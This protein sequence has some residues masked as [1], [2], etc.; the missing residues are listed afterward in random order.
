MK[1]KTYQHIAAAAMALLLFAGTVQAQTVSAPRT[2]SYQGQL[3]QLG[4][5]QTPCTRTFEISLYADQA[6]DS[7]LWR[8]NLSAEVDSSG[9]FNLELCGD[10]PL[11]NAQTMDRPIWMGI[12]IDN[13]T[14]MR[15]L[16]L[17]SASPYAL[18]V[19]DRAISTNKV[20]DGAITSAK[21]AAGAVQSANLADSSV[22]GAKMATDYVSA[23]TIN[24][25][26]VTS[27]G[28]ALNFASEKVCSS[29]SIHPRI[30]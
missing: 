30:R 7:L 1:Q 4:G 28:G 24:G 11:P 18:N 20:I 3:K 14:E 26:Q 19:A 17:L 6:G 15:P 10:Y 21:I 29:S 23:V 22:T 8:D 9:I 16:S 12:A 27:R 2:I 5:A 25:T 13:G